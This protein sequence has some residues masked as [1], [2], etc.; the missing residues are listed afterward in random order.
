VL[1]FVAVVAALLTATYMFRLLYM[2]FFGE[3][4]SGGHGRQTWSTR[5]PDGHGP[6][7]RTRT[8]LHDAPGR[9]Q[10]RSIVLAIGSVL[11]GFVGV[12]HVP[13]RREPDRS[14]SRA[15]FP[16][17]R[18]CRTRRGRCAEDAR[19]IRLGRVPSLA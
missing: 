11:A 8:H 2:S 5:Q 16:G 6:G 19:D 18:T 17:A 4:R 14:V 7:L 10:L 1:W 15:E 9:W 13:R 12:P 3:R